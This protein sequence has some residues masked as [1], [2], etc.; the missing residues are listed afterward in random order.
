MSTNDFDEDSNL[1]E[2]DIDG[3]AG[4]RGDNDVDSGQADDGNPPDSF[5]HRSES[6]YSTEEAREAAL[7]AELESV[8]TVNKVIEDVV[9]SL[10]KAKNNMHVRP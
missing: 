3:L 1:S 10:E 5:K 4:Q 7:R 9:S 6:R 2:S 8:R